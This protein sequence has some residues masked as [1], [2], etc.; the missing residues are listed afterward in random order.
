MQRT[1]IRLSFVCID[2]QPV[3]LGSL[4]PRLRAEAWT[5]SEFFKVSK[6]TAAWN[7]ALTLTPIHNL[8]A[9]NYEYFVR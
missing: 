2:A 4:S 8:L 5:L 7:C 6:H 1:M 9:D 3:V